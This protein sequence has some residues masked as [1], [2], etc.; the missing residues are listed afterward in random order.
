MGKPSS[1]PAAWASAANFDASVLP[2]V[3]AALA[4]TPVRLN[5]DAN[6]HLYGWVPGTTFPSQWF[7]EE[8]GLA[9][10]WVRYVSD[11]QSALAR[12]QHVV[13]T[14]TNGKTAVQYLLVGDGLGGALNSDVALRVFVDGTKR[15]AHITNG[16]SN[17]LELFYGVTSSTSAGC[18]WFE[19]TAASQSGATGKGTTGKGVEGIATSG[20]AVHGTAT[21]GGGIYGTCTGS[22]PAV[23]GEGSAVGV[24]GTASATNGTG[25]HGQTHASATSSAE[26]VFAEGRADGAG[27]R[28]TA[29][30]GNA[31]IASCTGD[32]DVVVCLA[33]GTG[34]AARFDPQT[35]APATQRA[36]QI[37]SLE[38]DTNQSA[39]MYCD[40][41]TGAGPATDKYVALSTQP[42]YAG[43]NVGTNANVAQNQTD[44]VLSSTIVVF[45]DT[46]LLPSLI[47]EG[48]VVIQP[49]PI[50]AMPTVAAC[51]LELWDDTDSTTI[52]TQT[53]DVPAD[54][55]SRSCWIFA[56]EYAVPADGSRTF[57]LRVS[58][59]AGAG[60]QLTFVK[61]T[62]KLRTQAASVG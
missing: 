3:A 40:N 26:G 13:E 58:T 60:G 27:L 57:Q 21:S 44:V 7:N 6:W 36:G 22:V 5:G 59:A 61:P 19:T 24:R 12:S 23:L 32:Q 16:A 8:L 43:A 38:L 9:I 56:D 4:G 62:I 54:G 20:Y 15:G 31:I 52:A 2:T 53:V 17:S 48:H 29:V 14:T 25:V 35:V 37:Y 41:S 47:V 11:A 42:H 1:A 45:A 28:A 34:A 10:D 55:V 39:L 46:V 49:S 51:V 18:A 30:D 50:G 33:S